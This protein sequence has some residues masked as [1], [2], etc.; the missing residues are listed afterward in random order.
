VTNSN[1][2]SSVLDEPTPKDNTSAASATEKETKIAAT[3]KVVNESKENKELQPELVANSNEPSVSNEST[4]K[5]YD[6]N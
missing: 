6:N 1:E 3:E 4:K 5:E 2:K